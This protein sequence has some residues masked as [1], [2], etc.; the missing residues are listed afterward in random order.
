MAEKFVIKGLCPLEGDV[1]IRGYKNAAGPALCAS[2]LTDEECTIGNL[3]LVED[4]F[5]I[6]EVIKSLGVKVEW[7]D[8]RTVKIKA[9]SLNP[10]QMFLRPEPPYFYLVHCFQG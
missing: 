2:L 1:E 6:I 9:D 4:V 8:D 5:N 3:P 10:E 7:I